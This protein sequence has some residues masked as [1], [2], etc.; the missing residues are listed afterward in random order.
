MA[1]ANCGATMTAAFCQACGQAA[2]RSQRLQ[3]SEIVADFFAKLINVDSCFMRTFVGL[4]ARPGVVCREYTDGKRIRYSNPVGY[5]LLVTVVSVL[6]TRLVRIAAGLQAD[7]LDQFTERWGA[8]L[9]LVLCVPTALLLWKVFRRLEFN[10]AENYV[11]AIYV[12]AQCAWLEVA[13]LP[14]MLTPSITDAAMCVCFI[15]MIG[16]FVY[17][18]RQFYQESLWRIVFAILIAMIGVS[19]LAIAVD[20]LGPQWIES[21]LN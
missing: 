6:T 1:C 4:S 20:L 17:A 13:F 10:L 3:V 18:A 7:A 12:L 14:F 15:G 8:Q 5:M 19:V 11:F 21:R 9:G 16:Y 2:E